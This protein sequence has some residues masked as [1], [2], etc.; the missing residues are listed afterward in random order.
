[1]STDARLYLF[2]FAVVGLARHAARLYRP[3]RPIARLLTMG[4]AIDLLRRVA[5]EAVVGPALDAA[6]GL[7]LAG[8]ERWV[9]HAS[10]ALFLGWG[11]AVLATVALVFLGWS[12]RNVLLLWGAAV[13]RAALGYPE[14]RGALLMRFYGWWTLLVVLASGACV[15][16]FAMKRVRP[17]QEHAAALWI[18][19][20]EASL[21]AGPY[22]GGDVVA[23]WWTAKIAYAVMYIGLI[24]VLAWGALCRPNP[25]SP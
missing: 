19:L 12:Y 22:L 24:P 13:L 21:L 7:P 3:F 1:V 23:L 11:A 18:L 25:S 9:A 14:L 6:K 20:V 5:R 16:R 17:R 10:Q 2:A 4:L 15:V 8:W